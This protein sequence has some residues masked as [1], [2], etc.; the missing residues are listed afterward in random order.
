MELVFAVEKGGTIGVEAA[1][2]QL[3][4]RDIISVLTQVIFLGNRSYKIQG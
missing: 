1:M 2:D 3:E 4:G